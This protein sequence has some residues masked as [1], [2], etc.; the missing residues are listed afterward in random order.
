MSHKIKC[1]TLFDITQTDIRQRSRI[2]EGIDLVKYVYQRNTQNNLDTILQII[3]L[4]SQPELVQSPK[5]LKI[6]LNDSD[7]FGFLYMDEQVNVWSFEFEVHHSNVFN[8]GYEEFGY[9]YRDCDGIPMIKCE[10]E[11][12]QLTNFLDI[13]PETKNIHFI[14]C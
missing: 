7:W 12:N 11:Y 1:Y 6:N 8:D 3:S 5:T 13:N 14:L 2:P 4:R 9:L 10:T